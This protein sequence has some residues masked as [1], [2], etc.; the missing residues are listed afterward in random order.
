MTTFTGDYELIFTNSRGEV[1]NSLDEVGQYFVE[2]KIT[3]TDKYFVDC[4]S[5]KEFY[6]NARENSGD[7]NSDIRVTFENGSGDGVEFVHE[8]INDEY[9]MRDILG[10]NYSEKVHH[11]EHISF[12]RDE[13]LVFIQN[14]KIF[15]ENNNNYEVYLYRPE[16]MMNMSMRN[17]GA[18]S[19]ALVYNN[20]SMINI[21][22][23]IRNNQPI[24]FSGSEAYLVFQIAEHDSHLQSGENNSSFNPI[25]FIVIGAVAIVAII[26]TS[27]VVVKIK[28]KKKIK[29]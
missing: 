8:R 22:D 7:D 15:L 4:D 9:I 27:I 12:K 3:E 2:V 19:F 6:V 23:L 17:S 11:I 10:Y 18:S 14:A 1:V 25:I 26:A 13:Q 5:K 16:V 24:D 20:D 28:K 21:T 29:Q